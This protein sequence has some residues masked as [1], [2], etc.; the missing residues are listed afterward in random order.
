[1]M[2]NGIDDAFPVFPPFLP[3]LALIATKGGEQTP[4]S[5]QMALYCTVSRVTNG[6]HGWGSE[7]YLL[8]SGPVLSQG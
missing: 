5:S 3:F 8:T 7:P 1:M 6:N 2:P 4:T